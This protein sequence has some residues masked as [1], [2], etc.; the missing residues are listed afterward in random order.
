M[1]F[2][3]HPFSCD[4][5]FTT[6]FPLQVRHVIF[7]LCQFINY[8]EVKRLPVY[9]PSQEEKDN[10]KLYASNVR[11]L[12]AREVCFSNWYLTVGFL[13]WIHKFR[14]YT[15][16]LRSGGLVVG[17]DMNKTIFLQLLILNHP[18]SWITLPISRYIQNSEGLAPYELNSETKIL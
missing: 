1:C 11:W 8:I 6:Y 2:S 13:K 7:L 9:Y 12:M 15:S 14:A 17:C 4:L 16:H 10:P 3:I 5:S 18:T